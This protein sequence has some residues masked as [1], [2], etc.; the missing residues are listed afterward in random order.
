MN[1]QRSGLP[2][3]PP[4]PGAKRSAG[5]EAPSRGSG[6]ESPLQPSRAAFQLAVLDCPTCAA[7]LDAE[8]ADVLFYCT[9]C[10]NGYRLES[11]RDDRA[12]AQLAPVDVSFLS[13]PQI[14]AER[15][16]PFWRLPAEV[17]IDQRGAS[18]RKFQ[19]R[20]FGLLTK[21]FPEEL[22][23]ARR[24]GSAELV[25]AVPAFATQI[26]SAQRLIYEYT[27][28]APDF[29]E[30]IGERLTGGVYGVRDAKKLAH[31]AFITAEIRRPDTLKNL[32][33]Q[34]DFGEPTL[35][36]VPAVRAGNGWRDALFSV[37][38]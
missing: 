7:P 36:G 8:A 2:D 10:R 37:P 29:G 35:L 1:D 9:A 32:R 20:D 5:E 24:R 3:L 18:G 14:A 6:E 33:Y 17:R 26:G 25:F 11:S 30:R 28:R 34:I 23:G 27:Y 31:Y 15:W 19:F 21:L 12:P 38:F 4:L 22:P 16:V 13:T